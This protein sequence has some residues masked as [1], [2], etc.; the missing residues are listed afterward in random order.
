MC[1][2]WTENSLPFGGKFRKN[3]GGDV[4]THTVYFSSALVNY[5]CK[6]LFETYIKCSVENLV[7]NV[8][9]PI[10]RIPVAANGNNA[11]SSVCAERIEDHRQRAVS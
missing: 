3:S 4:F 5:Q 8:D 1:K 10:A 2:I 7:R 11:V 6:N 9:R